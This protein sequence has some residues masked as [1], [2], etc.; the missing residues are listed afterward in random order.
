MFVL[1]LNPIP[2][3]SLVLLLTWV[4]LT[5]SVFNLENQEPPCSLKFCFKKF[6]VDPF[7]QKYKHKIYH[8]YFIGIF[9]GVSE[10]EEERGFPNSASV[11]LSASYAF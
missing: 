8:D 6:L 9:L 10:K 7:D 5:G 2:K 4:L 11:L 3:A 1:I